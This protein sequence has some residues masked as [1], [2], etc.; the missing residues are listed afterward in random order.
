M[1]LF[2]MKEKKFALDNELKS[3]KDFILEKSGDPNFAIADLEEKRAKAEEMEKRIAILEKG[4]KDEEDVQRKRLAAKD[5]TGGA[6]SEKDVFMK[7]KADFYRD[8]LTGNITSKSYEG[9]GGVPAADADLGNGSKLL[10]TNMSNTLLV[11]PVDQ[12]SLRDVCQITNITG[13]EEPKL[14]FTIEDADIKDVTDKDTAN[15]IAMEGDTIHYGR[16]KVKVKA[17]VKDTVLHGATVDLVTSIENKLRS[18]LAIR[19][20]TF[21]FQEKTA[22]DAD[23]DHKHMSFYAT[24]NGIKEVEGDDIISAIINAWADLPDAFSTGATVM[25]RK[26]DYYAAVRTLANQAVDLWGKKPEDVLGIPVVFNDKAK[27]PVVGNF[28]YYGINY[29]IGTIYDTD[30]D[31]DKGEYKFVLTAW[32]DQQIRMKSAFRLAKVTENP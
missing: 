24:D 7:A 12:N 29:D 10:P 25:M 16:Y 9:L 31:V 15:E 20:K 26:Q 4:I 1:T 23:T 32:G 11:E 2:E 5:A 6:V 3:I 27:I 13:L 30:K 18:A 22:A 28:A 21:A 14:G 19:E 8:A 17:T